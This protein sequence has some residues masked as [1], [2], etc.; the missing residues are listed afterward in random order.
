MTVY[1]IVISR[2][3]AVIK[4]QTLLP[5]N[6]CSLCREYVYIHKQIQSSKQ[7]C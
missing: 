3:E 6:I 5:C 2:T 1:N 4:F 7:L